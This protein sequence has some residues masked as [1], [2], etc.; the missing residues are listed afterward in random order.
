[1]TGERNRRA[2]LAGL[3]AGISVMA[4]FAAV[5]S[6]A[7]LEDRLTRDR[8][9]T[10]AG[11]IAMEIARSVESGASLRDQT[12]FAPAA[13]AFLAAEPALASVSVRGADGAELFGA[14]RK[15]DEGEGIRDLA[16]IELPI[17]LRF[18]PVGS[19]SAAYAPTAWPAPRG[20]L[21]ALSLAATAVA[22]LIGVIYFLSIAEADGLY[23]RRGARGWFFCALAPAAGIAFWVMA[24]SGEAYRDKARVVSD[25]VADR[26]RAAVDMRLDPI[27]FSGLEDLLKRAN[28]VAEGGGPAIAVS[29]V[30]GRRVIVRSGGGEG[31][32]A[33]G[34]DAPAASLW[35]H[36]GF[37]LTATRMIRPRTLEAPALMVAAEA[38]W[39]DV[40]RSAPR[41]HSAALIA[42]ML[43]FAVPVAALSFLRRRPA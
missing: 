36:S 2:L 8:V 28:P 41:D 15:N 11:A 26:L 25:T 1:M 14:S 10:Q 43:Y 9:A 5:L 20:V 6:V 35:R 17:G 24:A 34:G 38:S 37:A 40:V 7:A 31:A 27:A 21:H 16:V 33:T 4:A 3:F 29:L 39:T 19:V 12:G 13:R 22:I 23:G 32:A 30:E 42:L 18:E